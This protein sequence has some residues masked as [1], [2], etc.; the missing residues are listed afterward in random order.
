MLAL[1]NTIWYTWLEITHIILWEVFI[2]S[3]K[4]S[5]I[6]TR[7]EPKIK[8]QAEF[9]LSQL[10][11]SMSTAMS[12]Y[13]RQIALQRKI[14]FEMALPNAQPIVFSSLSDDEFNALMD[15]AAQSYADGKCVSLNEFKTELN[16]EFR[17]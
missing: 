2:M 12:I 17:L 1:C 5:N 10:G 6:M 11:I 16:K 4:S 3:A 8:E 9:V 15:K 7:V 13:L 14:P